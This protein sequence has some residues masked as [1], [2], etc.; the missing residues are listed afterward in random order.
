[1]ISW[2]DFGGSWVCSGAIVLALQAPA[3]RKLGNT[4]CF[5][6]GPTSRTSRTWHLSL[7]LLFLNNLGGL[8]KKQLENNLMR[9]NL[10]SFFIMLN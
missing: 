2:T 7:A 6:C 8:L 10:P 9:K 1:M 4:G 5:K 3:G